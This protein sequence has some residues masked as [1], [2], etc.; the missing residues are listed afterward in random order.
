M[1]KKAATTIL[2]N[3]NVDLPHNENTLPFKAKSVDISHQHSPR[4]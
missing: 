2:P 1:L 4:I 3:E